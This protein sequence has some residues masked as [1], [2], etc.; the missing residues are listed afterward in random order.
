MSIFGLQN[1]T[2]MNY[3]SQS[4]QGQFE[5]I[6]VIQEGIVVDMFIWSLN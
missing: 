2:T 4:S 5:G 1:T 3:E 6:A